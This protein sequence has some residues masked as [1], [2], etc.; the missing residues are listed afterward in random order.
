MTQSLP[1]DFCLRSN[2]E[3]RIQACDFKQIPHHSAQVH[4]LELNRLCLTQLV[5]F[6]P[7]TQAMSIDP[8]H[9]SEVNYNQAGVTLSKHGVAQY[10]RLADHDSTFQV[11]NGDASELLGVHF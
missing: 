5:Q 11:Q 10:F 1:K 9:A 8:A 3:D 6:Q 4:E 7:N 2:F